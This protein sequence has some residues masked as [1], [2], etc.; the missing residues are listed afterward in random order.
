MIPPSLLIDSL[1]GRG[2]NIAISVPCSFLKSLLAAIDADLR[3]THICAASEAE[4]VGIAA[5]AWLVG[6]RPILL[7]Q[8]SGFF[9]CLN[10]IASLLFPLSAPL[11]LIVSGRGA[12]GIRDEPHHAVVGRHFERFAEILGLPFCVLSSNPADLSETLDILDSGMEEVSRPGILAV[13]EATFLDPEGSP[14]SPRIPWGSRGSD[15]SERYLPRSGDCGFEQELASRISVVRLLSKTA[16]EE[17]IIIATTGFTG[18][19]LYS[20]GDRSRYLYL[21]GSMGCASAVGLGIALFSSAPVIVLDG[22]GAALMRLGNFA[23]IAMQ[24]P[25]RFLHVLFNNGSYESTGGQFSAGRFVSF[26]GVAHAC[27]YSQAVRTCNEARIDELIRNVNMG[28]GSS[29]TLVE[30]PVRM[31]SGAKLPR[32]A[33]S[34]TEQG[35]RLRNLF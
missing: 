33:V 30:I 28:P 6:R 16:V 35:A 26:C 32:P 13:P 10:S 17:S 29:P 27:G 25:P 7:M 3:I 12:F 21:A 8:N 1:V 34:M 4:A 2:V 18:R 9:E 31:A 24:R 5:G 23:T 19:E 14:D 20:C 11:L 15:S 22:D